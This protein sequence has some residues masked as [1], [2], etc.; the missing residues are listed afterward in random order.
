M[1]VNKETPYV[2]GL[3]GKSGNPAPFT[4]LG[5]YRGIKAAAKHKFGS[6]DLSN[7]TVAIQ[8]LGSVGFYLCEHLHKDGAKLIVTDINPQAIS[9]AVEQFGAV[10]V[11]L[12]EIYSVDADV[13]APCALGATVNDDTIPQLK[14]RIVAGCANNQLKEA[15]HGDMLRQQGILYAPDYVI[16][17]GGIINVAFEMRPEGYSE[18]ESSAKVM[19]IYDTLLNIFQR[20]DA[21]NQSTSVIADLMAQEIIR[22]GK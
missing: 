19:L 2:A 5:T 17:A 18:P 21:E 20:A 11:G 13:Y 16:N 9:R 14:A 4:A 8:G 1:I 6:D 22:R 3:E 7:R 10:A 12:D 15:R